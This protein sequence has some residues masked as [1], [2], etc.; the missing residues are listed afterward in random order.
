[1]SYRA[2]P[3]MTW[4]DELEPLIKD[5]AFGR[6]AIVGWCLLDAEVSR[7]ASAAGLLAAIAVGC[8]AGLATARR[9]TP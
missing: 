4:L 3:K 1:M 7:A 6:L 8:A 9:G 2:R 5:E